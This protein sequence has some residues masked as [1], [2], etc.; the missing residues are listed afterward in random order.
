[1]LRRAAY[2]AQMLHNESLTS[3]TLVA[4]QARKLRALVRDAAAQVPFYRDLYAAHGIRAASFETLNDL[5]SLPVVDKHLLRAAG[6]AARSMEAPA[7]G[8]TISTSGSTAEPFVFQIDRRYDQWRKAQYLRPYLSNGQRLRDKVFRL[9]AHPTRRM[10]WYSRLGLLREWGFDCAGDPASIAAAWRQLAPDVLQG[11]PSSLR[12]LAHHCLERG[13]PLQPAPRLVFTDSELLLPDTRDLIQR[14]FGTS[15]IDIFGTF[16]TD[17]IAYQCAARD[18]YHVATDCV[19]LEILRDGMPVPIG[20]EGE[21]V[22]TVLANR[23]LPF[24]RYNLRDI[25]R[26]STQRCSCGLPFPLLAMIQ[27]RANDLIVLADGRRCS[28]L[29][30]LARIKRFAD[31]IQQYQLR[32]LDIGCFELLVVPARQFPNATS[33]GILQAIGPELEDAKIELRLV[34]TIPPD[35]SGKRRAFISQ[36]SVHQRA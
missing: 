30:I 15:P 9:T 33:N 27:G 10:P 1:V 25:G 12:L 7:T 28:P 31:A 2:L 16:E 32:Q 36:L 8:V 4:R 20:E 14:A 34:A 6:A 5:Q 24:I 18:G 26:L 23:T 29:G 22:V 35:R 21:I 3:A 13:E 19:V 17:N 11:Y